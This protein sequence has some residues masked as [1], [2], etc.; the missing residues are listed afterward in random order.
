MVFWGYNG[1]S[2]IYKYI[3]TC[4]CVYIYENTNFGKFDKVV[5]MHYSDEVENVYTTLWEIYSG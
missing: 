5:Q 3:T 1:E 4:V 2:L